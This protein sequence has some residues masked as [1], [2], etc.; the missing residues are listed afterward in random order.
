MIDDLGSSARKGVGRRLAE[1]VADVRAGGDH[2]LTAAHPD[3]KTT[4][5][6]I[7]KT[8]KVDNRQKAANWLIL[9]EISH[10]VKNRWR[11]SLLVLF[12]DHRD[13]NTS[14]WTD[15]TYLRNSVLF[16]LNFIVKFTE[17]KDWYNKTCFDSSLLDYFS[18]C[19]KLT[20]KIHY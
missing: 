8:P 16:K 2:Q 3:L 6:Q 4:R 19:F 13:V 9:K 5:S 1:D 7:R 15:T 14:G 20:S 18:M 11:Y 17:V 10:S 12:L